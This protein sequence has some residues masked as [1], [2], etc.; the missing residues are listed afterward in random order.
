[1]LLEVLNT[2]SAGVTSTAV[3]FQNY[4]GTANVYDSSNTDVTWCNS[5]SPNSFVSSGD[6][7]QFAL[8]QDAGT[9]FIGNNNTWFRAGGAR[10]TFANATTVGTAKFPTGIRRRFFVGRGG[11]FAETYALN[12]GQQANIFSGSSTTFNAAADG[13]FVYTPP[14]G[15]KALNQD[16]LDDTSSKI[17]AL[18]WIK[19]R[20]AA[21][22]NIWMDRV[23]G[24]SGYL[25]TTQNDSGT[26]AT[27]F[28]DGGS[29]VLTTNA[30][31]VQRFLQRGVQVGNDE[32]VNTANESYVLWQWLLGDSATTGSSITTG[33]PSLATTGVVSDANHFSIVQYTGNGIDNATFAH[34]LGATPNFVMVKRISGS[35][36][37][38]DWV[39]HIPG[40]GTENYIYP[41][42]RIALATGAGANGMVPDAN[43]VEISTGVATNTSGA[44]HMAYSFKNT[45]GLCKIGTYTGNSSTDGTYVSTGFKPRF[46]WIFNT[47]LTSAD[48]E[49][50]IFDTARYKFNG[51]TTAGG[52]NGGINFSDQRAAEE[53]QNTSLG[54]NPAIDILS[55]G[56]KLRANDSTI[57]TGTTYLY[58]S[59]ADIAGGGKVIMFKKLFSKKKKAHELNNYR[60]SQNIRY[61]D[62]C[63]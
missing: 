58:I 32:K 21:D 57:N 28:G 11:S 52:T 16:N 2:G 6:V 12:F 26:A 43:L 29:D 56:F 35:A 27:S 44:T 15:Y 24:T 8:D 62:V 4:N 53:A 33:S 42:Y 45:P 13:Y 61:E 19:N 31:V 23:I 55:D 37:N 48:A 40:L 39:I 22:D 59:M 5:V 10:D 47:T 9:L 36:T 14:T 1:M 50:P 20:D 3:I 54:T 34:G 63:M 41:H 46:I 17:T 25:S 51:A 18:A 30:N 60:R 49:R 38:S 7:L